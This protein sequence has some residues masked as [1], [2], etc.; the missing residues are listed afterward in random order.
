MLPRSQKA[1]LAAAERLGAPD[2]ADRADPRP[3]RPHRL[4]RR[5]RRRAARRRGADLHA[6][7]APAREGHDARP[8]RGEGQAARRLPG[9]RPSR[10]GRS[11]PATASARSRSWPRPAT[12]RAR[13]R[14]STRATARSTAPTPS[15]R[16]A[17]SPRPRSALALPARRRWPPGTARPRSRPRGRCARSTRSGLAPGHGKV[18]EAPGRRDGPRRSRAGPERW[19]AAGWTAR[20]WSTR[21]SRSPTPTG[22]RRSR[23]PASPPRSASR[24]PSLYN[25]VD[26]R[27]ALVAR[28]AR[29]ATRELADA[30][31][32][33]ATGRAGA[34][35]LAAVAHA[36]RAYARAHPGRYAAT[37]AAPAPGDAEHEAAAADAVDV[38]DRGARRVRLAGDDADPRG[39]RATQRGARI[40]RDRGGRRLRPR[41][42]PRRLVRVARGRAR[43]R[44]VSRSRRAR[45]AARSGGGGRRL[46]SGAIPLYVRTPE[47][48]VTGTPVTPRSQARELSRR[49]ARAAGARCA[50]SPARPRARAA[51]GRSARAPRRSRACGPCP[52]RA[53]G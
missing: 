36:Q 10:R 22:S 42:R 31:R 29:A 1:I 23:S 28:I 34:D 25:H 48:E 41:R 7:R 33:A 40:R 11:P 2:R 45:A 37:V 18:V 35:A 44:I 21:R 50:A 39:A 30:L 32:R 49:R 27:E 38:L 13:S 51:A 52:S 17:A 4:A 26:G 20:R 5:A 9:R 3:R 19:R 47:V 6:R 15:P 12:R 8:R 43:G 14:S 53:A 46:R 16:S 24:S